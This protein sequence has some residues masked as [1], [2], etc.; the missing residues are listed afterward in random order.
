MRDRRGQRYVGFKCDPEL[1]AQIEAAADGNLSQFLRDALVTKLNEMGIGVDS[2]IAEAPS[3]L[4]KGGPK[5]MVQRIGDSVQEM[6][7]KPVK[8]SAEKPPRKKK[9]KP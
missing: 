6:P 3:R 8:Y 7:M 1:R 4:G 9:G 2:R 5:K